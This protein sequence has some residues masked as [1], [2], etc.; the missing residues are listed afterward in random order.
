MAYRNRSRSPIVTAIVLASALTFTSTAFALPA[1][2]SQAT[3][4][5]AVAKPK[6][7]I[8][9]GRFWKCVDKTCTANP[10]EQYSQQ[11][12]GREC[13]RVAAKFGAFESYASGDKTFTAEELTACNAKAPGA[14]ATMQAS[15]PQ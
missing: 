5:Q 13:A 2:V 10:S 4:V 6:T 7:V 14:P 9:D 3:L 15:N 1:G 12:Y 8:I 11:A